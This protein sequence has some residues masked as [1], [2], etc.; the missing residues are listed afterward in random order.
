MSADRPRSRIAEPDAMAL[1]LTAV[2]AALATAIMVAPV[3]S[4]RL[5]GADRATAQR[6]SWLTRMTAV[7]DGALAVGGLA[8]V[9]GPGSP[10]PWLIGA[11]AS[12]AV[13]ALVIAQALRQGRVHGLTATAVVPLAAVAAVSG[14]ITATR[15]ARRAGRAA[16]RPGQS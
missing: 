7:R 8:A 14:A 2:R 11:A 5:L 4:A 3:L 13:D 12:D 1:Q 6:V 10:T 15:C 9:R 16:R